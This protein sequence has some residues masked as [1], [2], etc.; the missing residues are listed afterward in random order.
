MV[1]LFELQG[2]TGC[3]LE[4]DYG[5]GD[6]LDVGRVDGPTY[7][8]NPEFHGR[9]TINGIY[10]FYCDDNCS[11]TKVI[12]D[13]CV[14]SGG[15]GS[16]GGDG[17]CNCEDELNAIIS[18]LEVLESMSGNVS[19]NIQFTKFRRATDPS[20]IQIPTN[21][22]ND[23]NIEDLGW[24]DNPDDT[25]VA[26]QT[27]GLYAITTTL[28]LNN[29]DDVN[30]WSRPLR[31]E[32]ADGRKYRELFIFIKSPN[33]PDAPDGGSYNF[34]TDE[35][36]PPTNW[37]SVPSQSEGTGNIY[38][39]SGYATG[40]S[41]EI[42]SFIQ[43]S[44]PVK[45]NGDD[46]TSL[47]IV[48]KRAQ[49]KPLKPAN[50]SLSNPL[51]SGWFEAAY[52]DQSEGRL[53]ASVGYL[54]T[55]A[56]EWVWEEPYAAE[57]LDGKDGTD[58]EYVFT[59]TMSFDRP[60]NN[61]TPGDWDVNPQYQTAD[62]IPSG[63]FDDAQ[64]VT[65]Q[66]KFQWFSTRKRIN[67]V[68]EPFGPIRLWN[69]FATEG[70]EG[71]RYRELFIY[72]LAESGQ[73]P[74]TPSGG[75]YSF[76]NDTLILPNNPDQWYDTSKEARDNS[77]LPDGTEGTLF[78]STGTASGYSELGQGSV[79][80]EFIT[81]SPPVEFSGLPGSILNIIYTRSEEKDG[82]ETPEPTPK[83]DPNT[84]EQESI[85]AGWVDKTGSLPAEGGRIWASYGYL[86]P[87][88]DQWI[89]DDPY[90]LEGLDG[91]DGTDIEFIFI[92]T[93]DRNHRPNVDDIL[94]LDPFNPTNPYQTQ[95]EYIEVIKNTE[96]TFGV[97]PNQY[98]SKWTDDPVDVDEIYT[99][100]WFTR[101]ERKS[102]VWMPWTRESLWNRFSNDGIDGVQYRELFI[103]RKIADPVNAA[104]PSGGSYNFDPA[105]T[106]PGLTPPSG[107]F[108]NPSDASETTVDGVVC[109]SVGYASTEVS[110]ID[111]DIEW[112]KPF[113]FVGGE[114]ADI[115]LIYIRSTN[116]NGPDKP[117]DT[118]A[119][120]PNS[121]LNDSLPNGWYDR[122]IDATGEGIL[123]YSIGQYH[124][125]N[126]HGLWKWSDPLKAE[127]LDG[128]GIEFIFILTKDE[129]DVPPNPTPDDYQD[130]PN[131]QEN[132]E[133][134]EEYI[135]FLSGSP[136]EFETYVSN[137][138]DNPSSVTE[139]MQILWVSTRRYDG[140]R[141]GA[142]SNP[143]IH[144]RWAK[145]GRDGLTYEKIFI[146]TPDLTDKPLNPTPSGDTVDG[147]NY[148][149]E[150]HPYQEVD[151]IPPTTPEGF[152]WT[153]NPFDTSEEFKY[154]WY[155]ER[156]LVDGVWRAFNEPSLWSRWGRDGDNYEYIYMLTRDN[157]DKPTV[158]QITP[159]DWNDPESN[160]QTNDE[161]ITFIDDEVIYTFRNETD[162]EYTT[163]W[164]DEA[165]DVFA[166]TFR[167]QWY[168][169]RKKTDGI[170]SQWVTP[171]LWTLYGEDGE[172]I[173]Y[174]Y[175]LTKDREDIPANPT[176]IDWDDL[177]SE[178]QADRDN[179]R[180]YVN[181]LDPFEITGVT[182]GEVYNHVWL[183]DP[184]SVSDEFP[185]QWYCHRRRVGGQWTRYTDPIV[186]TQM[187]GQ[188]PAGKGY[189]EL[190]IYKKF[191]SNQN[192]ETPSGGSF[193]F[194]LETISLSAAFDKTNLTS[195]WT[196]NLSEIVG[197][198]GQVYVSYGYAKGQ[199]D[200]TD[201]NIEWS[202]PVLFTGPPGTL[203]N[204]IYKR[205]IN[206][207]TRPDNT[208]SD[209]DGTLGFDESIPSGWTND[210]IN[211]GGT[212]EQGRIWQ[213]FGFKEPGDNFWSWR[214][215]VPAEPLDGEDGNGIEYIYRLGK[216]INQVPIIPDEYYD[217]LTDGL[218]GATYQT[219]DFVPSGSTLL[220]SPDGDVNEF[221]SDNLQNVSPEYPILWVTKRNFKKIID[222]NTG[223]LTNKR[224][225]TKFETPTL[226]KRYNNDGLS[227]RELFI[228]RVGNSNNDP[229]EYWDDA[230]LVTPSGGTY[231]FTTNIFDP[232]TMTQ[233]GWTQNNDLQG[234]EI[235]FTSGFAYGTT[236]SQDESI[237]WNR[238][239]RFT[240]GKGTLLNIVYKKSGVEDADRP[241]TPENIPASGTTRLI[242]DGWV[243][244]PINATGTTDQVLW[245]SVGY[246][247]TDSQFWV[248][249]TPYRA[250]ALKPKDGPGREF[251]F[252][253]T[254]DET[255]VPDID[256]P[257]DY[258]DSNSEGQ[259]SEFLPKNII[260]GKKWE[261]DALNV[262]PEFKI[263][264][265][266]TRTF[267][268]EEWGFFGDPKIISRYVKDGSAY[269]ELFIYK[270]SLT[271]PEAPTGGQYDFTDNT[272]TVPDGWSETLRGAVSGA[273]DGDVYVS[274]GYATGDSSGTDSIDMDI[275]WS[276]PEIFTGRDGTI[277]NL[278]YR[279][280]ETIPNT[281]DPLPVDENN[282]KNPKVPF[283]WYDSPLVIPSGDTGQLWE[284]KGLLNPGEDEWVFGYPISV[285]GARGEDGNDI[286]FIFTTTQENERP[287]NPTPEG[288]IFEDENYQLPEYRPSGLTNTWTD[289]PQDVT[290][291]TP[292]Q[293]ASKRTRVN[294]IW[295]RFS[296]PKLWNKYAFDGLEGTAYKEL[297]IYTTHVPVEGSEL[298][299]KPNVGDATYNFE[300]A[301]LQLPA[302]W[303]KTVSEARQNSLVGEIFAATATAVGKSNT[304][305]ELIEWS[306]P[307]EFTGKPGSIV[308]ILFKRF[309]R[310]LDDGETIRSAGMVKNDLPDS[311]EIDPLNRTV[312]PVNELNDW[313][314]DSV[315]V[316]GMN[317]S[318]L[319]S[320]VAYLEPDAKFWKFKSPVIAEGVD[321]ADGKD[322]NGIEQIFIR[323]KSL[324]HVPSLAV[325]NDN[326]NTDDYQE[327]DEYITFID[328]TYSYSILGETYTTEWTDDPM[329][330][331]VDWRYQLV[332]IRKKVNGI[333]SAFS[334]PVL[335][336]SFARDGE[337]G[338]PGT[339]GIAYKEIFIYS[340]YPVGTQPQ[341][342]VGGSYTFSINGPSGD[343]FNTPEG[344]STN[345][346]T[347]VNSVCVEDINGSCRT[348]MA[349]GT[350][351]GR[352]GETDMSIEWSTPVRV[353]AQPGE[354]NLIYI[355]SDSETGPDTPPITTK[356]DPIPDGWSDDL[357]SLFITTTS[358]IWASYGINAPES[359]NWIWNK[360][361]VLEGRDGKSVEYIYKLT[362]GST[363][364][365]T[366]F[367][368]P[369]IDDYLPDETWF[370]EPQD[371]NNIDRYLWRSQR[372]KGSN[373][374]WG[375]YTVPKL[376]ARYVEQGITLELS[377]DNASYGVTQLS[378]S[379]PNTQDT[380]L[381][382][383]IFVF[384][385]TSDV[386]GEWAISV[387]SQSDLSGVIETI[388]G[389]K[390]YRVTSMGTV[391]VGTAR[392]QAE[393][394][395]ITV[396]KD[397]KVTKLLDGAPG[398]TYK[399]FANQNI[400]KLDNQGV[401]QTTSLIVYTQTIQSISDG[402]GG[403]NT[404]VSNFPSGVVK[405][406]VD[407]SQLGGNL[408]GSSS[409]NIT[410]PN[411]FS[412]IT[413]ELYLSDGT[414]LVD[415]ENINTVS[416]G[417]DG[418]GS[419]SLLLSNDSNTIGVTFEQYGQQILETPELLS[420]T[421]V[422]SIYQ[423]DQIITNPTASGWVFDI[424][425]RVGISGGTITPVSDGAVIGGISAITTDDKGGSF[426]I[427]ATKSGSSFRRTFKVRAIQD[428]PKFFTIDLITT[429]IPAASDG[430]PK[431][432][433]II[434][435]A[436]EVGQY[437]IIPNNRLTLQ[438][439]SD[440]GNTFTNWDGPVHDVEYTIPIPITEPFDKIDLRLVYDIDGT[441]TV[442]VDEQSVYKLL[443]GEKG[444]DSTIYYIK[445]LNGT[446]IRNS[447]GSVDLQVVRVVGNNDINLNDGDIKIYTDD[448]ILIGTVEGV[449]GTSYNPT[450][451]GDAVTDGRL[452][453]IL[454]DGDG[455]IYDS[456]TIAD[457]MDGKPAAYVIA[458]GG[459]VFKNVAGD[460][461]IRPES[462][463][464]T[465]YFDQIG[466][467]PN[468]KTVNITPSLT[469]DGNPQL[470]YSVAGNTHISVSVV[471][472][473]GRDINP[474]VNT[475]TNSL[476][477]TFTN[478]GMSVT[479]TVFFV[480]DGKVGDPGP[481][482]V[483]GV[484]ASTIVLTTDKQ[485]VRVA[486]NGDF[487]DKTVKLTAN[488]QNTTGSIS[489]VS[490]PNVTITT[491]GDVATLDTADFGD[492]DEIT[493]T[494]T[495]Q[496]SQ[497]N[498]ISDSV[499]ITKLKEGES[500]VNAILTNEAAIIVVDRD[501]T[502][503]S[504]VGTG[505]DISVYQGTQKLNY[506]GLGNISSTDPNGSWRLQT[507]SVTP[508][509]ISLGTVTS[510]NTQ[511]PKDAVVSGLTSAS[512]TDKNSISVEY[513]IEF[514][515]VNG[516]SEGTITK[517]QTF[518]ISEQ[519]P[520]KYTWIRYADNGD[521]GGM[522]NSPV[523][524]DY[525]GI[526]PDK[527]TPNESNDPD[528][529]TWS[530]F[531]GEDGVAGPS[532][533]SYW[534]KFAPNGNP[535]SGQMT[536][537]PTS[538]T[539]HIGISDPQDDPNESD[540]PDDY[541]WSKYVGDNGLPT[542]KPQTI[543]ANVAG[544]PPNTPSVLYG[545]EETLGYL[546]FIAD[547][548]GTIL[549]GMDVWVLGD[550]IIDTSIA[551]IPGS[552]TLTFKDT[553]YT[554][555]GESWTISTMR[556][557][558]NGI[559][560][561][562][563]FANNLAANTAFINT[564]SAQTALIEK[565]LTQNITIGDYDSTAADKTGLAYRGTFGELK[566]GL[567][568]T[569]DRPYLSLTQGSTDNII[570]S[571]DI[572]S[573]GVSLKSKQHENEATLQM[574]STQSLI[575][576]GTTNE[577]N[578]DTVNSLTMSSTND[579][580]ILRGKHAD[581]QFLRIDKG[582]FTYTSTI[583]ASDFL[584]SSD[585]NLKENITNI[586]NPLEKVLQLNGVT[587]DWK[588]DGKHDTGLIAQEVEKVMP[589]VVNTNEDGEKSVSYPKLVG[590]LVE[591]IKELNDKIEG[592]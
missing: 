95:Q 444:D 351:F 403:F 100:Q 213:S 442:V 550:V 200:E 12:S 166:P 582:A 207:P 564:L 397:F 108:K 38:V 186:W 340:K 390:R 497:G 237:Q 281:P 462:T 548:D 574:G 14:T 266:A 116:P 22:K 459:L 464:L 419:Y 380:P 138:T 331:N 119:D 155:V 9:D 338:D 256:Y 468:T 320:V 105:S 73:V 319:W 359:N 284:S 137:W 42:D 151:Y 34:A 481:Q 373:G 533:K 117:G 389:V 437:Y 478:N 141:W 377:N 204:L 336:S 490:D 410:L 388:G 96:F 310:T 541:T 518:T 282:R 493:F 472:S 106:N 519:P 240:A 590:L 434:F 391:R 7:I 347:I 422:A 334:E 168:T 354:V 176:P 150:G 190:F 520:Q 350:A 223:Q 241:E 53:W 424:I 549:E 521:G 405:V 383:D 18:R 423:G 453:L 104:A 77:D 311:L 513:V 507:R 295:D 495:T 220:E 230:G 358:R 508:N 164:T 244:D 57:G 532:G 469:L 254:T 341:S 224:Y 398:A 566:M 81:W 173:E 260:N 255:E 511:Q 215:P 103:Y 93:Q 528:D 554:W 536:N 102:G 381:S 169:Y 387:I 448:D 125:Q 40:E 369:N 170:W 512:L 202:M 538:T 90:V 298:P 2:Y 305:D 157:K 457:L 20:A 552:S 516:K 59:L 366:P 68:W 557:T 312:I 91:Q 113:P 112:S 182:S 526:A 309:S 10:R 172:R 280:Q 427:R 236:S 177:N 498:D 585:V 87:G 107:W 539:T 265:M 92:R 429:V 210:I 58:L 78:I 65:S 1:V 83:N 191:T 39:S 558:N 287:Q 467:T 231:N 348:Y 392:I 425:D 25:D 360:P 178:Y 301:Q 246:L 556:K 460:D 577:N 503:Q 174:I 567:L 33:I 278:I 184:T 344:W 229:D 525:I 327:N 565:L 52:G 51:P 379:V 544:N 47:N 212:A 531:K 505:T 294:G 147:F 514:K 452:D 432:P 587:F 406:L 272:F 253:L 135:E 154:Q 515:S 378:D 509:T 110:N 124:P 225:W 407:G 547:R 364:P 426:T 6:V 66:N 404:T 353:E 159:D 263:L 132:D 30:G 573:N 396:V 371:I 542:A 449:S 205:A 484:N 15:T 222:P 517:T 418:I 29:P 171:K 553:Q 64:E 306:E 417:Q 578:T 115:N 555:N 247:R 313:Y 133:D 43:W 84:P 537:N 352:P 446:V 131:Y 79:V 11:F 494:A 165:Q 75:S 269:R 576:V 196:E 194:E 486:Q 288:N 339:S 382:T 114:G 188:G 273:T 148:L 474:N 335:W 308:E 167:A 228:F 399:I 408:T 197:E 307:F 161:Y 208:P 187:G 121:P 435:K 466:S 261:D 482:G 35:F 321:G 370:D 183:D 245:A 572:T 504:L 501:L 149:Q 524:K 458:T 70:A 198:P 361:Y 591:A 413:L 461:D 502:P 476:T 50:T 74:A 72:R 99:H 402:E 285:E 242:P 277:I 411:S 232:S 56:T 447:S 136:I 267:D 201:M 227:Y 296:Q 409:Y 488:V 276:D 61:L 239:V 385:G 289:D 89:W 129:T 439:S 337:K 522:S 551:T 162:Q 589:E 575:W 543:S 332:S 88:A 563:L 433:S 248:F 374:T 180:E 293:W 181:N 134:G 69:Q 274:T 479:E 80:D 349:T 345:V 316:P 41:D 143:Q 120:D 355:G 17:E 362:S 463:S 160:Y 545:G 71:K 214:E 420:F 375:D 158:E 62:Y 257:E 300:T 421:T 122:A 328:E 193:N 471:D 559:I 323:V 163:S 322:G 264:W 414:T 291:T 270:R 4:V 487:I 329:D 325:V 465:A 203:V 363:R 32:G 109:V 123:W 569:S 226:D 252:I 219:D 249:Q 127:P 153:D 28:N 584:L 268:G 82:P 376:D 303:Y 314:N 540:D 243:D 271:S 111:D 221:W 326:V 588:K 483:P 346:D 145:D 250:E 36:T 199:P 234:E 443:D 209:I 275:T 428:I 128:P 571:L 85:P 496:D 144:A 562:S 49:L 189:K 315:D 211:V 480:S 580:V 297:F 455:K 235:Y 451:T 357:P 401:P 218:T 262:T 510:S 179:D 568:G 500:A 365:D 368:E 279:R 98:T 21:R 86:N 583:T 529:Y 67:G 3:R 473:T 395:G 46:G 97:E 530:K 292:Y 333:W 259:S 299:T 489:W 570:N 430:T 60:T 477:F 140:D 440:D 101:R 94:P 491:N 139:D 342:V 24:F 8:F 445:P 55:N 441:N 217:S 527:L 470:R 146:L 343:T 286:E 76:D 416:D 400:I 23:F 506:L 304:V 454:K 535:T 431:I 233:S 54:Y 192:I 386:T 27:G 324:A 118:P 456:I 48:Y 130:N 330:V 415:T 560:V 251:I 534:I 372:V 586:E 384:E 45:F 317:D 290:E 302:G 26:G 318:R 16:G 126:T 19:G 592:R 37:S 13:E 356:Q 450:I 492:N 485:V 561:D 175:T 142:F 206:K 546:N 436:G 31:Y 152:V 185:V 523:G 367:S 438:Y 5:N 475:N 258:S 412:R 283:Q 394:N 393:K 195:G 156:K 581:V 579:G 216:S 44:D 63:W 499:T 238:P